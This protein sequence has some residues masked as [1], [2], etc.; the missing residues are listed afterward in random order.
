MPGKKVYGFAVLGSDVATYK[1]KSGGT[2]LRGTACEQ[3]AI[4]RVGSKTPTSPSSS[5]TFNIELF[6]SGL[7]TATVLF[8]RSG[9][10]VGS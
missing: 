2:L 1:I 8:T 6:G 10:E 9:E 5:T 4:Y 3:G 7:D